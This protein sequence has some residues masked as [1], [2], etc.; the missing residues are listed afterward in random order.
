MYKN[1]RQFIAAL[2]EDGQLLR[3]QE[4]HDPALEIST[5][6]HLESRKDAPGAPS[7][8]VQK[9]DPSSAHLGGKALLLE[10][11]SGSSIP[12]LINGMGSYRRM[13]MALGCHDGGHTPGGFE[14]IAN[15]IEHL[16]RPVPPKGIADAFRA[17]DARDP[18]QK[19]VETSHSD[20][21]RQHS[22]LLGLYCPILPFFQ[23]TTDALHPAPRCS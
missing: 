11:V 15:K 8:P 17:L 7:E 2:E 9:S 20:L 22:R 23:R 3:V 14:A 19:R 6:A 12:V 1:L 5:M 10:N 16:S 4:E 13:E 21:P 18:R